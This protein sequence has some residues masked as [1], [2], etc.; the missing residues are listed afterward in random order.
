[1]L[2]FFFIVY[3]E[4]IINNNIYFNMIKKVSKYGKYIFYLLLGSIFSIIL[5]MF[6]DKKERQKISFFDFPKKVEA[7]SCDG[8]S[9]GDDDGRSGGS[10]SDAS[11][12]GSG[13]SGGTCTQ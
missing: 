11:S 7:H 8:W 1:M 4:V 9:G 10:S 2:F 3:N 13:G 6:V 5:F 12:G